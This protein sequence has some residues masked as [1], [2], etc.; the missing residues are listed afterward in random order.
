MKTPSLALAL[1]MAASLPGRAEDTV[2]ALKAGGLVLET[3]GPITLVAEDLTL[4]ETAVQADYRFRNATGADIEATLAFPI[5]DIVGGPGMA[6]AIPDP[7]HD[8]VL[9]FDAAVDDQSVPWQV[10]Q[11][12]FLTRDGRPVEITGE[13]A[14]LGIPLVP[15]V[16]ATAVALR[17][18]PESRRRLLIEA[19][20]LDRQEHADG[21]LA[22]VP[23]WT[24]KSR[25]WRRQAFPA[26]RELAVRQRF[27]PSLA[28][29]SG[30]SFGSPD[31]G[32]AAMAGY[33]D[34]FCTDPAFARLA[35]SLYRR[36]S[37]D[38]SRSFQAYEESLSYAV[39]PGHGWAGPIGTF[40]LI[41]DKG[42][43]ATMV[44]F[45]GSNVRKTGP[46]TFEMVVKDYVPQRD[47]DILFLK[48]TTRG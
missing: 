12:A 5:P 17:R 6:V 42:D 24:L 38:G 16:D 8:N 3:T 11:H 4:S 34:R 19:R 23:L 13:L 44:S 2:A 45:C 32:P 47:I 41:V 20:I 28:S 30:L 9:G 7:A 46:T 27:V 33:A 37:A 26:G 18:L 35:Q 36:A 14:G 39:A 31:L 15:T 40:R 29:Q 43:P 1:L 25:F 21:T 22:D 10:E 48:T